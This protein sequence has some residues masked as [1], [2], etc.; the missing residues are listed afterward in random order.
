MGDNV[1]RLMDFLV[2][3]SYA[4]GDSSLQHH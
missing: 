2:A 3:P 4:G 1:G